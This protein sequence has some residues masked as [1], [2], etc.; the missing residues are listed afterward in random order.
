MKTKKNNKVSQLLKT[1][2]FTYTVS[3][4]QDAEEDNSSSIFF[5]N[6]EYRAIPYF[7]GYMSDRKDNTYSIVDISEKWAELHFIAYVNSQYSI[8]I[9]KDCFTLTNRSI[10]SERYKSNFTLTYSME[11]SNKINKEDLL[12]A[13]YSFTSIKMNEHI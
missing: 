2:K 4:V 12:C 1:Y 8:C 7:L 13:H 3:V 5:R 6:R 11:S 9:D 10:R